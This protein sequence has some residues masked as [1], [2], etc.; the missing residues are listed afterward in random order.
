MTE[1]QARRLAIVGFGLWLAAHVFWI[2]RTEINWD[3]FALLARAHDSL[4]QGRLLGGGRPGLSTLLLMP[5][6]E[7]CRD[8]VETVLTARLVWTPFAAGVLIGL[9]SFLSRLLAHHAHT[10]RDTLLGVALL[11]LTPAFI[12]YSLQVRTDQPAI[13]L[14]LLGGSA[15]LASRKH[16]P[17]AIVAGLL[18]GLGY[19]SSQKLIYVAALVGSLAMAESILS[20]GIRWRRDTA[21]AAIVVVSAIT[22]LAAF[23]FAVSLVMAPSEALNLGAQQSWFSFYREYFGYQYY[24]L[25]LPRLVV[26]LGLMLLVVVAVPLTI[27]RPENRVPALLSVA[28]VG[29][30]LVVMV[31]HAGA[32]PYFWMTLGLFPA[33]AV[34]L[35][36]PL[37]RDWLTPN[38]RRRV[39]TLAISL[40]IATAAVRGAKH[41]GDGL[42]TQRQAMELVAANFAEQSEGFHATRGLFC[43]DGPDPFPAYFGLT[44]YRWRDGAVEEFIEE[45]RSRPVEFIVASPRLREFPEPVR[46]FWGEHYVAY[47]GTLMVPGTRLQPDRPAVSFDVLVP[48]EYTLH[49][50]AGSVAVELDGNVLEVGQRRRLERGPHMVRLRGDGSALLALS[51]S[52]PPGPTTDLFFTRY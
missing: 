40:L 17:W 50:E 16:M 13:A 25:M 32:L 11:G 2:F 46:R 44:L 6:V 22:M 20:D 33:V 3:E 30:G 39:F 7:G 1:K 9:W 14:G 37:V 38:T 18:F 36:M 45:F 5:I 23:K 21:R 31:F 42:A 48:G 41:S 8:S 15:L 43:R 10:A 27:R 4:V 26:P 51:V 28:V 35:G 12:S 47:A 24:L 29:L 19:S 34:A 52:S 49:A